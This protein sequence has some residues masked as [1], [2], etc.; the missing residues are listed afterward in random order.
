MGL[1][2]F[3]ARRSSERTGVNANLDVMASFIFRRAF[4]YGSLSFDLEASLSFDLEAING[5][6]SLLDM[7]Y[8]DS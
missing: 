7:V 3:L 8:T 5:V 2:P 6:F 1:P 4:C